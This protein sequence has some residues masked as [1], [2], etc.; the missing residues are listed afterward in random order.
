MKS[1]WHLADHIPLQGSF[2]SQVICQWTKRIS[3][4]PLLPLAPITTA[5]LPLK[6]RAQLLAL[7]YLE[8][9]PLHVLWVVLILFM[10]R[11]KPGWAENFSGSIQISVSTGHLWRDLRGKLEDKGR[12]GTLWLLNFEPCEC[13]TFFISYF[14]PVLLFLKKK[15]RSS[16]CGAVG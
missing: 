15:K 8:E 10:S 2:S 1:T 16:C 13:I 3:L 7:T 9:R 5:F 11:R 4:P 14:W 12:K 6:W